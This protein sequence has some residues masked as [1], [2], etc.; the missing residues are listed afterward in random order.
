MAYVEKETTKNIR[1]ALKKEFPQCR[2]SVKKD[3]V[4]ALSVGIMESPFWGD[5]PV[6]HSV[7]HYHLDNYVRNGIFTQKQVDVLKRVDEIIRTAGDYFDKSDVMSDYFHCAFYY[8]IT[9]GRYGK[10]H[11]AREK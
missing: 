3:N 8:S 11:K 10:P 1:E 5:L 7:N 4:H 9:V 2:F 6:E